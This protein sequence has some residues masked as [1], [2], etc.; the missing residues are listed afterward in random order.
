MRTRKKVAALA[1]AP[2]LAIVVSLTLAGCVQPSPPVIPTSASS[3]KPVFASDAEALA[4][5]KKAYVAYL[6]VSDDI[7]ADGGANANRLAPVVS[8]TWL[9]TELKSYTAF[10]ESGDKTTGSSRVGRFTLEQRDQSPNG[11]V[12]IVAYACLDLSA[13]GVVDGGGSV[14]SETGAQGVLPLEVSFVGVSENSAHLIL[15]RSAPW[16][17]QDFCGAQSP[18]PSS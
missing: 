13:A 2:L 5:A 7:G 1:G 9:P 18:S 12:S 14:V 10:A 16:S 17:G 6:A 4:A 3:S 8:K 11:L 15:D